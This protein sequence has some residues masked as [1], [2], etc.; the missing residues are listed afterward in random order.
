MGSDHLLL[1]LSSLAL[2]GVIATQDYLVAPLRNE[3]ISS[4]LTGQYHV[5]LDLAYVPL[6]IALC[7]SFSGAM[8]VLGALS[9]LC[10]ILVAVTNTAWRF[11]DKITDGQHAK[12]HSRF[13][14]AVFILALILQLA[15]DKGHYA[16][17]IANVLIPGAIYGFFH[18]KPTVIKG[19]AIEASPAAEKAFVALL[20]SW[21]IVWAL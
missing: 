1:A 12:W 7:V 20:C 8:A 13:T 10:L 14:L 2:L 3:T 18:F 6:A 19:V 9:A 16:L 11:T 4:G 17:T 21:L 15:G 5:A